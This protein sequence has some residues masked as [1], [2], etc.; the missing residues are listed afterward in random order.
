MGKAVTAEMS[1]SYEAYSYL[2]VGQYV[3]CVKS[4]CVCVGG[5][6]GKTGEKLLRQLNTTCTV[7][8]GEQGKQ[9]NHWRLLLYISPCIHIVTIATTT[10]T[11]HT[12][13]RIMDILLCHVYKGIH[14]DTNQNE[15]QSTKYRNA[16]QYI[17]SNCHYTLSHSS[18]SLVSLKT[19]SIPLRE[20][21]P[22]NI[23][24]KMNQ[25]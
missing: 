5:E 7:T 19:I 20:K 12:N 6:R 25:N 22:S 23:W 3:L 10:W 2:T 24:K 17:S 11:L 15:P 18:Q 16:L 8:S 21:D 14:Y 4:A 13:H 1:Y 9:E